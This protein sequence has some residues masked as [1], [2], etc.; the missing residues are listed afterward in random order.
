MHS[1][2]SHYE[3]AGCEG[4]AHPKR[5]CKEGGLLL[6]GEGGREIEGVEKRGL[7]GKYFNPETYQLV[8]TRFLAQTD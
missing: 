2:P 5:I 7:H 6:G 8:W 3:P 1:C 4:E